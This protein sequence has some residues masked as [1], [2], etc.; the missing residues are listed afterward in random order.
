MEHINSTMNNEVASGD[1]LT[2]R[3][4]KTLLYLLRLVGI[5]LNIKSV[6]AVNIMYNATFIVCYYITMISLYTDTYVHRHELVHV[7]RKIH[8]LLGMNLV[9]W[10]HF[11]LRYDKFT[12]FI[13]KFLIIGQCIWQ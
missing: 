6:S 7:M 2:E 11:S 12:Y 5:P 10:I 8:V 1:S 13:I 9:A 4:F 3:R